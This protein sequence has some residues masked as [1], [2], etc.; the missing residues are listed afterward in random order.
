MGTWNAGFFDDDL[1][2]DIKD[3]FERS[4]KGDG[5]IQSVTEHIFSEYE[6][7]INDEDEGPIVYLSLAALQLEYG[8]LQSNI[9]EQALNIINQGKGLER[10]EEAGKKALADREKVLQELKKQLLNG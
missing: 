10:W 4:F 3:E 2:L 9:K 8:Y 5:D 1:A 7:V 6:D